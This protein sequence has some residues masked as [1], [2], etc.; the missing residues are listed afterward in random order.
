M[1]AAAA[2]AGDAA[3]FRGRADEELQ[4]ALHARDEDS[5]TILHNAAS[6][7]EFRRAHGPLPRCKKK[8]DSAG[9]DAV[10]HTG[11]TEVVELLLQRGAGVLANAADD[12]ARGVEH[13]AALS[14]A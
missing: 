12:E 1:A 7:G 8:P 14:A 13:Y 11:R 6:N 10:C 5:R 4:S 2:A 3:Y 9:V